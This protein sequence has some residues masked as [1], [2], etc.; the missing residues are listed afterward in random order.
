[1]V[2]EE[3]EKKEE[4]EVQNITLKSEEKGWK[5]KLNWMKNFEKILP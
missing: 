3:R 5:K 1:M 2:L 4:Q